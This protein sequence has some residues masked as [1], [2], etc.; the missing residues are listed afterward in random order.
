MKIIGI[1]LL[2]CSAAGISVTLVKSERR[3]LVCSKAWLGLLLEARDF[4]AIWNMPAGEILKRCDRERLRACGYPDEL[5]LPE[6]FSELS[7]CCFI[8]DSE[9]RET[10]CEFA[11]DFGWGYREQELKKT[12]Q[13]IEK[14]KARTALLE[15]RL[16]QRQKLIYGLCLS[17]ALVALILLL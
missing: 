11:S 3:R 1:L 2:L 10:I 7:D 5:P 15:G 4:V 16:L 9:S 12:E 6:S 14:L 17:A 13:C 8:P